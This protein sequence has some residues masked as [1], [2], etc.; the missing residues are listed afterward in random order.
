MS[1]EL[2]TINAF[3]KTVKPILQYTPQG[4]LVARYESISEYAKKYGLSKPQYQKLCS[5]V[6]SGQPY[7]NSYFWTPD[8]L[9]WQKEQKYKLL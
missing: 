5:R 7:H 4:I 6:D 8:N 1:K 3:V 9:P 2:E